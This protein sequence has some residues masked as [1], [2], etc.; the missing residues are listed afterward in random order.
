MHDTISSAELAELLTEAGH[1][2][3]AYQESNGIDPEWATWYAPYL[4]TRVGDRL[5][6]PPTRS[7]LV[8][9]LISAEKA[10]Q[11]GGLAGVSW[12]DSYATHIINN[13]PVH[14]A[15]QNPLSKGP[16]TRFPGGAAVCRAEPPTRDPPPAR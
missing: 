1:H 4:Q 9:L 13:Y 15:G 3:P 7:E 16:S 5:G 11:Q 8:Y 12:S 14:R 2:H 6:S 10:F